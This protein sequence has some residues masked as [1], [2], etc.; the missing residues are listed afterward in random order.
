MGI[1]ALR[2]R[3]GQMAN[4][5]TLRRAGSILLL[6][7][8][9]ACTTPTAKVAPPAPAPVVVAPPKPEVAPQIDQNKV[10][11]LLPLTGAN[12]AVGQS[13]ANAANM[14]LLDA[15]DKRINLR[16]YD[17]AAGGAAAAASRAVADGA[18]LFLG[19]LLAADVRAVQGIASANN[20]P[21][22]S[23]SNDAALAGD[24]VYVMG[25][26]PAQSV[27]R[28]VGYAATHGVSR[29]A[30]LVPDGTYGQRATT[31]FLRAVEANG[32]RVVSIK[33][34]TRDPAKMIAAARAVTDY[35][36]RVAKAATTSAVRPDG[37]ITPVTDR[38]GPVA[39]QALLIADSGSLAA[40]FGKPLAQFGAPAGTITILGTELWN[41]EP[42]LKNSPALAGALFAAVPDGRFNQLATRYRAKFGGTPSRL[43]SFGYD[44][45]LLVN[46]LADKWPLGTPFPRA[47]LTTPD[48][49]TGIDGIF[50]FGPSG[51]A[52]RGFEVQQ[53]GAGRITTVSSAPKTLR[54]APPTN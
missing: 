27:S 54:A 30:A 31:A 18:R 32:G 4:G 2:A 34:F 48:G 7:V 13:I 22:I 35:D 53:I 42:G 52:E 33:T 41:N 21:I 5:A 6:S 29:F 26:Q 12:A 9:A 45:V 1:M 16:V 50:R 10:A 3:F 14:A 25:L 36:A 51:I 40:S 19:P 15:G 17:T 49:F 46:T 44:S 37:T 39:F 8:I 23:Y 43:A 20:I 11:V 38:I 47:A 28:V 24:G